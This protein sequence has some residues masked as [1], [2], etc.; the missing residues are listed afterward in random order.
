VCNLRWIK[1]LTTTCIDFSSCR[2]ESGAIYCIAAIFLLI[3]ASQDNMDIF[4]VGFAVE[5]QLLVSS[6]HSRVVTSIHFIC[7]TDHNTNVHTGVCW[8]QGYSRAPNGNHRPSICQPGPSLP[9][10]H[11]CSAAISAFAGTRHQTAG[12]GREVQ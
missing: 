2:L 3:A 6:D 4:T 10:G 11:T 1:D 7:L 9:L 8:S 5:Q 12:N